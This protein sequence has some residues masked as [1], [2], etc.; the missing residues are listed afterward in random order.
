MGL[1]GF[2]RSRRAA[3]KV[4][5]NDALYKKIDEEKEKGKTVKAGRQKKEKENETGSKEKDEGDEN[6]KEK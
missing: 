4:K 1:T 3:E 6:K 2:N 5:G